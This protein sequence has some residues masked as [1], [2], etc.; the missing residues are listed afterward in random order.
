MQR[1]GSMSAFWRALT[2]WRGGG[3]GGGGGLGG[4][5]EESRPSRPS[6]D[7]LGPSCSLGAPA[8]DDT[9]S[10]HRGD[11]SGEESAEP[12]FDAA[13]ARDAAPPASQPTPQPQ[14]PPLP[15]ERDARP[16]R[17]RSL[18]I[19]ARGAEAAL[20][21]TNPIRKVRFC[22]GLAAASRRGARHTARSRAYP[23]AT[24]G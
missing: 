2:P 5:C 22:G 23:R 7:D 3:G 17:K 1:S 12:C 6:L 9:P 13:G 18:A 10:P 8:R 20:R 24:G 4:G 14:E 19:N 21:S 15:P 11:S 16:R